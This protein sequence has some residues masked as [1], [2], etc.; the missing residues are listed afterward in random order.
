VLSRSAANVFTFVWLSLVA[1]ELPRKLFAII[2]KVMVGRAEDLEPGRIRRGGIGPTQVDAGVAG[3][4]GGQSRDGAA[5][6]KS[7]LRR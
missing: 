4:G 3:R 2:W 7:D 5:Q 1:I 6:H